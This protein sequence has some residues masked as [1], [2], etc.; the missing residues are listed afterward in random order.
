[1]SVSS[2]TCF[3]RRP[4]HPK[5]DPDLFDS[6]VLLA[7][8][9]DHLRPFLSLPAVVRADIEYEGTAFVARGERCMVRGVLLPCGY[10]GWQE[11]FFL[12]W[13]DMQM[14][15]GSTAR[16]AVVGFATGGPNPGHFY[17]RWAEVY[18]PRLQTAPPF[19]H[20]WVNDLMRARVIYAVVFCTAAKVLGPSPPQSAFQDSQPYWIPGF[21]QG[22]RPTLPPVQ[23]RRLLDRDRAHDF[24]PGHLTFRHWTS[25][26]CGA[27]DI[28]VGVSFLATRAG[29]GVAPLPD[30]RAALPRPP[31]AL[32]G[33]V[34]R[35]S[36]LHVAVLDKPESEA[37]TLERGWKGQRG[38]VYR[39]WREGSLGYHCACADFWTK[40]CTGWLHAGGGQ[41]KLALP[42]PP[43]GR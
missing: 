13:E 18:S 6:P 32:E 4:L 23:K 27:Q 24:D 2:S 12:S 28:Y 15:D 14:L 19:E 25:K 16:A 43:V 3:P 21:I 26:G 29:L 5:A 31:R 20:G 22:I 8:E 30:A 10:R 7:R 35:F 41:P 17:A 40:G 37:R 42:A 1:M 38:D 9:L 39:L 36:R 34:V 33:R 11:G